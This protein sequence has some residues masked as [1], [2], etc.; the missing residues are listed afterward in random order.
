MNIL[1]Y[2]CSGE[3]M[4]L[5]HL[6]WVS[7]VLR[8]IEASLGIMSES[9]SGPGP[10]GKVERLLEE[11]GLEEFGDYLVDRWTTEEPGE[12]LSLRA[13]ARELNVQ[14]VE[15][16]LAE[17]NVESVEGIAESYYES[18]SGDDVS[19]GV[20]TEV[21]RSLEQTGIDIDTLEGD[22][23][24][25]QAIHTYLTKTRGANQSEQDST[26]T[27]SAVQKT[28]DRLRERMRQVTTSRLERL[29]SATKL[30]LGEFRVII[31]VQVYCRDCGTQQ[32]ISELIAAKGCDCKER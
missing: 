29:R 25:R 15:S 7:L 14:L 20:Q 1:Y 32:S 2:F 23:V 22:F 30:T 19:S 5:V 6:A 16:R 24:S 27:E 4:L 10:R 12:R 11:Y 31:D 8:D 13:L 18:L 21:R 3:T 26:I 17:V 28:I 9:S